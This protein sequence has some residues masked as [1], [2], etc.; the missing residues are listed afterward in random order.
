MNCGQACL[1]VERIYVERSI[2]PRFTELCVA[3]TQLLKLGP[4]SD[5][6]NEVGPMIRPQAVDRVEDQLRDA[7]A[8]GAHVL[9]GGRRRPDLGPHYFEPTVV[10]DVNHSMRITQEDTFGPVLTIMTVDNADEAVALANDSP[11]GLSA[12]V[13][14]GDSERGR[15]LADAFALRRGYGK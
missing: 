4:G 5:P 8:G 2:A 9:A 12:S 1:S 3:K 7:I 15:Q 6:E 13:W 14:T 11:F 10:A